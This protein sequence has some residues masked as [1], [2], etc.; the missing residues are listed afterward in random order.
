MG[1]LLNNTLVTV[2]FLCVD[3]ET[4]ID[5]ISL[6]MLCYNVTNARIWSVNLQSCTVTVVSVELEGHK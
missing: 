5:F 4:S 2:Y 1:V 6:A 3:K